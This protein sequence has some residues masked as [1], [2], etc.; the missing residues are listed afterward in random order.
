M[1]TTPMPVSGGLQFQAVSSSTESYSTCG[2]TTA[3]EAYCWGYNANGQ[4]GDG[5]LSNSAA[6]VKVQFP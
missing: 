6:P 4:L 5:T 2:L 3:G 1:R